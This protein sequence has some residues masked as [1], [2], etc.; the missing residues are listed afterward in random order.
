MTS[1]CGL[2]FPHWRGRG[3]HLIYLLRR[4][5]P[6]EAE[7]GGV[8]G[9]GVCRERPAAASHWDSLRSLHRVTG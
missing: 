4:E 6:V 8:G 2:P 9:G 1:R 5:P 7:H 3:A